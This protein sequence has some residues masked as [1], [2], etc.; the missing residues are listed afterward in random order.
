LDVDEAGLVLADPN[1]TLRVVAS[2]SEQARF[3]ELFQLQVD[4]GPCLDCYRTGESVV[5]SDLD[6]HAHRWPQFVEYARGEGYRSVHATPLKVPDQ[7]IGALNL[8]STERFQAGP[9]DLMIVR[10]LGDM[11]AVA[12]LYQRA[13]QH[14]ELVADQLQNALTS[15]V[16]SEQAKGRLAEQ[17]GID[18]GAAFA[19]LR[20]H[21]RN[22]HQTLSGTAHA[23]AA[24]TLTLQQ[25]L[26]PTVDHRRA[27]DQDPHAAGGA[28]AGAPP[29]RGHNPSPDPH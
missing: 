13:L 28:T 22:T 1:G 27:Q 8:F 15:R 25:I 17:G 11:A 26:R 2:T 4:A 12:V 21:A 10:A 3:L 20:G 5:V 23:V 18:M 19:A 16:V 7:T 29:A 14:S 9:T 6:T 24:G